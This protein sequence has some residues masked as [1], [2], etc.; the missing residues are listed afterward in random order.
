MGFIDFWE[1]FYGKNLSSGELEPL[2]GNKNKLKTVHSSCFLC[3]FIVITMLFFFRWHPLPPFCAVELLKSS[4][5][6]WTLNI[7]A[8][9]RFL[10]QRS[11]SSLSLSLCQWEVWDLTSYLSKRLCTDVNDNAPLVSLVF[12]VF[13]CVL[14][15]VPAAVFYFLK[16]LNN[17]DFLPAHS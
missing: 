4:F 3:G 9:G 16:L 6:A 12:S 10:Q 8:P 14:L 17:Q 1:P 2:W 11:L 5:L 7:P 13:A 15:G